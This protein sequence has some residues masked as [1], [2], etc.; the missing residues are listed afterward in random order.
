MPY[1]ACLLPMEETVSAPYRKALIALGEQEERII[2][3]GADLANSTEIDGFRER[4]PRRFFNVGTA[5]QNM[6]NIAAGLA[7][8]GEIPIVHTFGVF[9]TRRPYEQ[10][11]VQVAMHRANVKIIGVVPGLTSR[12]GPTHQ[13]IDD[14][15]LMRLLPSLTVIDPADAVEMEQALFAA[16]A[17]QGPVYMRA[18]RREVPVLFDA[19]RYRFRIGSAVL[20]KEGEDVALLSCGLMLREALSAHALLEKSGISASVLHVPTVKPLDSDAVLSCARTAKAVVTVENHLTTG[21]LG[22]AVAEILGSRFPVP[23]VRV[24]VPDMFAE[25]GSPDYLFQKYGLTAPHIEKA[26]LN[27][28]RMKESHGL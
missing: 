8:E 19:S 28:I 7:F 2:V 20:L 16:A 14:L 15:A 18:L 13:A 17:H 5:E 11:C 3:L 4:F 12:L 22:S 25:P 23:L 9:A 27:A 10:I 21:G 1:D 26:A 6:I 24:G